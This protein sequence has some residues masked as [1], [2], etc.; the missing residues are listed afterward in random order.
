MK[1]KIK[2]IL[3]KFS[4]ILF[5]FNILFVVFISFLFIGNLFVEKNALSFD[6]VFAGIIIA[7]LLFLYLFS[8]TKVTKENDVE[9]DTLYENKIPEKGN[10]IKFIE[11]QCDELYSMIYEYNC[12][13]ENFDRAIGIITMY[14]QALETRKKM[15][16][17]EGMNGFE[18]AVIVGQ[19]KNLNKDDAILFDHLKKAQ[20]IFNVNNPVFVG[21][22]AQYENLEKKELL[23]FSELY[24][25]PLYRFPRPRYG[26]NTPSQHFFE[27]TGY[28]GMTGVF[29]SYDEVVGIRLSSG[30]S[31][32]EKDPA[33]VDCLRRLNIT[34]YFFPVDRCCAIYAE[35]LSYLDEPIAELILHPDRNINDIY[36]EW[37]TRNFPYDNN[38][39]ENAQWIFYEKLRIGYSHHR[40]QIPTKP[41]SG[42]IQDTSIYKRILSEIEDSFLDEATK[43]NLLEKVDELKS[44]ST[45]LYNI[46]KVFFDVGQSV[47]LFKNTSFMVTPED[48]AGELR[49]ELTP[50]MILEHTYNRIKIIDRLKKE[51]QSLLAQKDIIQK[52]KNE[53]EP[54]YEK[55]CRKAIDENEEIVFDIENIKTI[56]KK[57]RDILSGD[58]NILKDPQAYITAIIKEYKYPIFNPGL[59]FNRRSPKN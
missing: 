37:Y 11:L 21:G 4:H 17:K 6:K 26:A 59:L 49:S 10:N 18:N 22:P 7:D 55:L 28:N 57:Y 42:R 25:I 12:M 40:D 44:D 9:I 30:L 3:I 15:F 41:N 54:I 45:S 2:E 46:S 35:L 38:D 31:F 29:V 14:F 51:K 16:G 23:S 52:N 34:E 50:N 33:F 24:K 8:T 53:I 39:L 32:F 19:T 13:E 58:G 5:Y 56:N 20:K 36:N 1:Q 27:A 48:I 43:N 47:G